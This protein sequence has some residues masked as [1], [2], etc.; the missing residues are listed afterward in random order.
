MVK[1]IAPNYGMLAIAQLLIVL[2]FVGIFVS[3]YYAFKVDFIAVS[4]TVTPA[5]LSLGLGAA[6]Y[7]LVAI[8]KHLRGAIKKD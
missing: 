7:L 6:V 8:E 4:M 1:E 5:L 2:G 3:I